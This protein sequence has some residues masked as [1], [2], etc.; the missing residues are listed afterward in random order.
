MD[1]PTRLASLDALRGFDMFFITG[2]A[3]LVCGICAALGMN[4]SWLFQQMDHV[5]WEG[6]HHHDTIFPLFLFLAGV[7]F[8][9]SLA[10]QR[11][12]GISTAK[13]YLRIVRRALVL[14]AF[15]LSLGGILRFDPNFRLSSVL[16]FIGLSWGIAAAFFT[17]VK[18]SWKRW[19]AFAAVVLGYFALLHFTI[20]P[21]SPALAD[22]YSKE[23]NIVRW[24]DVQ[25][26]PNHLFWPAA[27][28]A[29]G[30]FPYD[31]ES[32]MS[33]PGGIAI[34]ML[35]M[36]AGSLLRSAAAPAVKALKL[37]LF[38][39]GS[40]AAFA[41]FRFLLGVPVVKALWT[42]SFVFAAATYSFWMLA[43][44]Y[45]LVDVRGWRRWTVVFDP[46]GKNSIL[47]Y[48][49]MSVG[50]TGL[51]REFLFGALCKAAGDWC[52]AL[53]GLTFYLVGWTILRYCQRKGVFLKV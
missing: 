41:V 32:L 42:V 36:F 34:A 13:I 4:D 38:G 39:L 37:A 12:K 53:E 48:M 27:R 19:A 43:L 45:Y 2:G 16:G 18:T 9:F 7:S 21:A 1:K 35:G 50:V 24:F 14:F 10:S 40:L 28:C 44:F 51:I 33:L 22:G 26:Y 8:P 52:W 47:V 6:F 25:L 3:S 46:V 49:L 5:P 30:S 29:D 23:W 17:A 20:N 31:P 15:G 11:A